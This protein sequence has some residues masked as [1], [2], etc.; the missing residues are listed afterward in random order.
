MSLCSSLQ[1]WLQQENVQQFPIALLENA[2]LAVSGCV[3]AALHAAL[4]QPLSLDAS[5]ICNGFV[6]FPAGTNNYPKAINVDGLGIA[7]VVE[8]RVPTNIV[9]RFSISDS[10]QCRERR[11]PD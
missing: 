10:S 3:I 1:S 5:I 4:E 7:K 2:L 11:L 9:S 8:F 6:V